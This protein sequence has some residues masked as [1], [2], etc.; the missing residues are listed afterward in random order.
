MDPDILTGWNV[1]DFKI[2]HKRFGHYGLPMQ[3]GRSDD[4]ADYLP[5][6]KRRAGAIIIPGRQVIDA[7][8]LVRA[9]PVRFADRSLETVARAVLGEGKVQV[10]STD[11]AKIDALMRTYSEDPITFCKYCL[12]DAKLVLEIL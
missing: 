7:L 4:P 5:G 9:G 11:E 10:Q 2:I 8:R 1:I 12:M 6:T 3:I